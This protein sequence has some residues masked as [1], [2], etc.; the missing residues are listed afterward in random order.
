LGASVSAHHRTA[1]WARTTRANRPRIAATLP[2][3][4]IDCGR[5]ITADQ[6]WQVGH[7]VP[8]AVGKA[9]GWSSAEIN[10]P[11]N[12]GPSHTKGPGQKACNQ[13]AG[14]RLGSR[15]ATT[16]RRAAQRMP[17]W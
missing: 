2:A 10:A 14:G 6:K 7:R 13:I 1:E 5:M 17:Q 9:M 12:L 15:V 3:R 11:E 16:H 8:A 4:C